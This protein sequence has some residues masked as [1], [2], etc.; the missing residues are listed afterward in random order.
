MSEQHQ[1]D[2]LSGLSDQF[3]AHA[4]TPANLGTLPKPEGYASPAG[5]CGDRIELYLRVEKDVVIDARFLTEGCLHTVAC[6]SALTSLIKGRA[7]SQALQVGADEVE[8]ELGG[9]DKPHRHCAVL[10]AVTLKAAIRDYF[11]KKQA[12]WKSLYERR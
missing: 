1:D 3:L 4:L 12:P 11:K 6:G 2:S 9:L 5:T 8:E 7:V 10:A